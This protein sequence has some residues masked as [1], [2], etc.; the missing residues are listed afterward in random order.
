MDFGE[1][2]SFAIS[3]QRP[4]GWPCCQHSFLVLIAAQFSTPARVVAAC[5]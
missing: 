1:V 2:H 5:N 4:A 3:P